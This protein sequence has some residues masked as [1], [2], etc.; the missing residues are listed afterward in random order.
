MFLNALHANNTRRE[1]DSQTSST[2]REQPSLSLVAQRE[3]CALIFVCHFV[4]LRSAAVC[5]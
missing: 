4:N 5:V 3:H 2:S 1:T